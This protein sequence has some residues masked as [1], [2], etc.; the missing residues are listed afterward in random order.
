MRFCA[1]PPGSN[2]DDGWLINAVH[3]DDR[4]ACDVVVIDAR[5]VAAG[6]V[7]TV[8]LPHRMPFGFHANWFPAEPTR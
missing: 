6:P 8:R 7:A 5:D 4:N 2:E 3:Y 1:T